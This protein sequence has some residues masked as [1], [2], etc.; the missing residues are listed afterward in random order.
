MKTK[1]I[2]ILLAVVLVGCMPQAKYSPESFKEPDKFR[3]AET[4]LAE[5]ERI[6]EGDSLVHTIDSTQLAWRNF[7]KDEQL[8]SLINEGLK[9]N[10][11]I[12]MAMKRME[13]YQLQF[14]QSKLELLPSVN[15][16]IANPNYQFRS[17][18]FHSS[19]NDK[20]Y[21]DETPPE[22]MFLYRAQH[23]SGLVFNWE[24]D[25]WGKI[26]SQKEESLFEYLATV[27]AKNAIQTQLVADIASGYYNLLS[28]YAQLDVAQSNYELSQRT[29]R[30]V[31]LQFES[32]NTTALAKQQ[33]KSLM[34]ATK[35]LIPRL[36]QKISRQENLLQLLTGKTVGEIVLSSS[37]FEDN[38]KDIA[39]NYTIPLEMVSY[40]PDVRR[41]EH[42]LWAANAN[43][44]VTQTMQYPRLAIDLG[45]GVNAVLPTNWFNIPGALFGSI[46]GNLTQPIF[47]KKRLK[48]KF[49]TAKL[50][51]EIKEIEFQKTVYQSINEISN[52]LTL[53]NALDEQ[54]AIAEEQVENSELTISQSNLLFNSG[55]ATYLEVINAQK[56]ALDSEI[57]LSELKE[58]R[59]QLRVMLYKAL[60]G[61][62]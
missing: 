31:K 6:F 40:R 26:R 27:E 35:S 41:A 1:T 18:D 21:G 10:F 16:V 28:L 50:N 2:F 33:T 56:V 45:I 37:N 47:N 38:Y 8:I 12:R 59:L 52:L 60:G 39:T 43:V 36:K 29:L 25:I 62:W 44:G 46:I 61:G 48:T 51:R 7:F 22:D 17:Q 54:I 3:I 32:G 19:A 42:N 23:L 9:H 14:K 57:Q 58:E 34:L 55:Y 13:M 24:I 15:A 4:N 53:M 11:D 5:E 30:M 20:W 49:E